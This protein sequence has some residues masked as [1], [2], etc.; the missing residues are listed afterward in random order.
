MALPNIN[1]L[2][3]SDVTEA[4]FKAA[5]QQFLE[6]T[7]DIDLLNSSATFKVHRI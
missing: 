3:G 2:I 4:G 1:D 6:N 7:A 5:L